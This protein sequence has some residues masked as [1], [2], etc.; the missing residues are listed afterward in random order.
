[1]P[2]ESTIVDL[3]HAWNS[4]F[5]KSAFGLQDDLPTNESKPDMYGAIATRSQ[6]FADGRLYYESEA[7]RIAR[8]WAEFSYD[9]A[10]FAVAKV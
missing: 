8:E 2:P 5:I 3:G 10:H 6:E 9:Q 1:M 4:G 7:D